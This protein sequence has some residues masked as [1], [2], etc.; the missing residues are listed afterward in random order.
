MF[1]LGADAIGPGEH[2][3]AVDHLPR[4]EL[5]QGLPRF[6]VATLVAAMHSIIVFARE[7]TL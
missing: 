6:L 4:F 3:V 7:Y 2:L 5:G 1:V